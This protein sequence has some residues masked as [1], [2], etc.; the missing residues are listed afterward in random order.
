MI[1]KHTLNSKARAFSGRC[2]GSWLASSA[3]TLQC[4]DQFIAKSILK[5][6]CAGF[7]CTCTPREKHIQ[8]SCSR[9]FS[10]HAILHAHWPSTR[11]CTR[12]EASSLL[13]ANISCR[14]AGVCKGAGRDERALMNSALMVETIRLRSW[15][16]GLL[17]QMNCTQLNNCNIG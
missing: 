4:T 14:R 16:L 11:A 5:T 10:M 12:L 15:T 13:R 1:M 8:C 7:E 9:G 2:F 6:S 17:V 3:C